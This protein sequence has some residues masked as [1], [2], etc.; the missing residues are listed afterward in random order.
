MLT[1]ENTSVAEKWKKTLTALQRE[2]IERRERS[3]TS[4]VGA[5]SAVPLLARLQ[6]LLASSD[7]LPFDAAEE[8]LIQE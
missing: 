2:T 6:E 7:A 4:G 8:T 1:A 5:G 3:S